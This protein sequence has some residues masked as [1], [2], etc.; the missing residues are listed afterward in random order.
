MKKPAVLLAVLGLAVFG[1]NAENFSSTGYSDQT[2]ITGPGPDAC[3]YGD[4][5]YNH[6]GSFEN[7][8]CWQ[9]G[10][11]VPPSYGA[12][13]EGYEIGVGCVACGAFWLT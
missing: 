8:Y 3:A 13:G 5:I 10:G 6:D 12:F 11:V 7:G 2:T 9:Y 1:A 4:L